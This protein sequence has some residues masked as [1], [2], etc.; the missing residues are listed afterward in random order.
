MRLGKCRIFRAQRFLDLRGPCRVFNRLLGFDF[1][2]QGWPDQL[3]AKAFFHLPPPKSRV[4][5]YTDISPKHV[6]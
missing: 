1:G 4:E 5:K 6:A 3:H 2:D